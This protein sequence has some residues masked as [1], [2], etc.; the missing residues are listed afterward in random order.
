MAACTMRTLQVTRCLAVRLT[1]SRRCCSSTSSNS[2]SPSSSNS[3]TSSSSNVEHFDVVVAG[4]GMAGFAMACSLGQSKILSD[5]K[6]LVLEGGPRTDSCLETL[7]DAQHSNRVCA[8]APP[9]VRLLQ[10]LG[11]W[12]DIV[13]VRTGTVKRM[14]VWES[15]SD[16]MITF[17]DGQ[18]PLAHI[19]EN[20]VTVEALRKHI[21]SSVQVRYESRVQGYVL[22]D[23]H[24]DALPLLTLQ[25]GTKLQAELLIGC[26]GAASAVRQAMRSSTVSWNYG[27]AAVVATLQLEQE[28]N[29]T[30][31][32]AWQKFLPT[33]PLAILPLERGLSSLV[34]STS[35]AHAK[36][37]LAMDDLNFAAAINSAMWS[38]ERSQ[39]VPWLEAVQQQGLQVIKDIG[40]LLSPHSTSQ[41][42]YKQLP[43][44]VSGV[45]PGSRASFPLGLSHAV[46]YAGSRVVLVGDAAHRVHPL[47]GQGANMGFGDVAAL[48][49]ALETS[50]L[51]GEH[52]G[53]TRCLHEYERERQKENA[54]MLAAT[55]AL[56][57]LYSTTFPPVVLLRALGLSAVHAIAPVKERIEAYMEQ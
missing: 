36:A 22:P 3:T 39:P 40:R 4:G 14:Q 42:S 17:G 31:T 9:T 35:P 30:N 18:R 51:L 12:P 28:D 5:L 21:P 56:Q 24:S 16:S 32:T 47:A 1:Y 6:I 43:P 57:R 19:V 49:S 23:A 33:G 11:V 15:E 45:L 26:D 41:T 2:T 37:L 25:D 13:A 50:L 38:S 7:K 10:K 46:H 55:D 53:T 20:C 44:S 52:V 8:L 34:W 54:I 29:E 48:T 27:Q